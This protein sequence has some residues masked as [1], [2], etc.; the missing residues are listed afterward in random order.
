MVEKIDLNLLDK[1]LKEK[2]WIFVGPVIHYDKALNEQA[3]VY[4]KNG[5]FIVSGIAKNGEEE[6]FEPIN[7]K[8]ALKRVEESYDEIKKHMFS[9]IK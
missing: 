6:L 3:S 2:G 9:N 1:K 5:D 4:K 8:E 7:K